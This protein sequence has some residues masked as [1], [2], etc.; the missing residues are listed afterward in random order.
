MDQG[1]DI[2]VRCEELRRRS[3]G[4][5]A[6]AVA[7]RH[8][9]ARFWGD[10]AGG[11]I[12]DMPAPPPPDPHDQAM[13]ALKAI[14]AVLDAFPLEWQIAIVKALTARTIVLAHERMRPPPP[15]ALSA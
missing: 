9:F 2:H 15:P 8:A 13:E 12:Y 14:R 1:N 5:Q 7:I 10:A 3:A 4:I 11:R 6:K